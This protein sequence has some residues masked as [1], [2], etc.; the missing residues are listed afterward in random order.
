MTGVQTCALPIF[1]HDE[2]IAKQNKDLI[3]VSSVK[4][5][6]EKYIDWVI[7]S[8]DSRAIWIRSM[9]LS[10]ELKNKQ[11][12]YYTEL[13]EPSHA[14]ALDYLI[15]KFNIENY[16][17]QETTSTQL[18]LFEDTTLNELKDAINEKFKN[19][20]NYTPLTLKDIVSMTPE[21][22]SNLKNC[23]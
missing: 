18:E 19:H 23:L 5:A 17:S 6:V 1:T 20:P 9:L 7:N 13:G 12:L 11:I 16:I 22:I 14:T 8:F 21:Q 3:K 4:E 15:N 2:R 10:G